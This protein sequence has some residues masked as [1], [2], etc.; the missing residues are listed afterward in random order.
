MGFF[1]SLPW[2]C[3]RG[4][5]LSGQHSPAKDKFTKKTGRRIH[6]LHN[7]QLDLQTPTSSDWW[8]LCTLYVRACQVRVTVGDSDL[9]CCI[10]VTYF[11]C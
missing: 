3:R 9:C 11:E 2:Q 6:S 8:S 4:Y 1:F 10:F 5:K 7:Q